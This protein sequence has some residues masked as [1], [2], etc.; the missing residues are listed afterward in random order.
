MIGMYE[1]SREDGLEVIAS[2]RKVGNPNL[3]IDQM[4]TYEALNDEM[5]N[6]L[7]GLP[8]GGAFESKD[9][10]YIERL[11][12]LDEWQKI[13]AMYRATPNRYNIAYMEAY[14]GAIN[15]YPVHDSAFIHR[16][17]YMDFYIDSFWQT[18][19][20]FTDEK[21]GE[22]WL[23]Q[24]MEVLEPCFN[25]HKYQNYPNRKTQNFRWAF[26]GDAF[27]SLLFVKQ[28][29]DPANFF[30]FGQSISPYP[31]DGSVQVSTVP[32]MF[33]DSTVVYEPYSVS[34]LESQV[35]EI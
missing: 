16:H 11:L 9:G 35:E 7:P 5:L 31:I 28:K 15:N 3:K 26:W 29:Y 2:L 32:S 17:V 12:T 20:D 13:V 4:E 18:A 21:E 34:V 25:G 22:I 23:E 30:H 8:P 14:G 27:N 1:G 6:F 33:S 10:G 24:Y 19:S